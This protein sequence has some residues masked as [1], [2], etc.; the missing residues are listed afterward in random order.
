[1][2]A[3]EQPGKNQLDPQEDVRLLGEPVREQEY[4]ECHAAPEDELAGSRLPD[5]PAPG[6]QPGQEHER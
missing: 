1:M 5:Q 2:E 4:Q 6:E 3:R